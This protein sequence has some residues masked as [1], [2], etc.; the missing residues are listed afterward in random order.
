MA[1]ASTLI[2]IVNFLPLGSLQMM[3]LFMSLPL[4]WYVVC[5]RKS[6]YEVC[7]S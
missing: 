6:N 3:A 5:R 2:G 1:G 4:I 7:E